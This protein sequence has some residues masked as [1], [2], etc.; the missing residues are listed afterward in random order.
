[1]HKTRF[2]WVISCALPYA[3]KI[4]KSHSMMCNVA[5]LEDHLE[6]LWKIK[7]IQTKMLPIQDEAENHFQKQDRETGR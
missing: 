6:R 4:E 1:M 5:S 2:G 3:P 7:E